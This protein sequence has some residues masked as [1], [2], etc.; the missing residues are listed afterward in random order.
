MHLLLAYYESSRLSIVYVTVIQSGLL[1]VS[2]PIL[3]TN[4]G[5]CSDFIS[6]DVCVNFDLLHF[7]PTT[8]LSN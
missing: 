3:Y 6:E 5:V 1:S 4:F 2:L 8:N 7:S